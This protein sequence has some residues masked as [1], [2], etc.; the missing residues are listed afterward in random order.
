MQFIPSTGQLE[1]HE[2]VSRRQGKGYI[3]FFC[4]E[5]FC[6]V[7]EIIFDSKRR[8]SCSLACTEHPTT[9]GSRWKRLPSPSRSA[10]CTSATSRRVTIAH[11]NAHMLENV[12][13]RSA[14][15]RTHACARSKPAALD[16][17]IFV[18]VSPAYQVCKPRSRSR[19]QSS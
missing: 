19:D 16:S 17:A 13:M 7:H 3:R 9:A 8:Y 2:H 10:L 1:R 12:H 11:E 14:K 18:N 5:R 6:L 4:T 15:S